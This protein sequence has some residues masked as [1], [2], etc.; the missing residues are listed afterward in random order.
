MVTGLS[1]FLLKH[2]DLAVQARQL[3]QILL[4]PIQQALIFDGHLQGFRGS[5]E[6]GEFTLEYCG[7]AVQQTDAVLDLFDYVL[8]LA[9]LGCLLTVGQFFLQDVKA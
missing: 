2:L 8:V 9:V 5:L 1:N 4:L 7:P 3:P 6:L